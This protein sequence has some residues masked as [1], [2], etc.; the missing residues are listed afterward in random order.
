MNEPLASAAGNAVEVLNAVEFL[1]GAHRDTRLEEVTLALAAELLVLGGIAECRRL[2]ACA[3][4]RGAC[5]TGSA[6]EVFQKMVS[7]LGGPADFVA[8]PRKHLPQAKLVKAVAS[9]RRPG[10]VAA[11]DARALGLAVVAL[12]GGRTRAEDAIDHAVGLT[13]LA[14]I[15]DEVGPDRPLALVHARDED[16]ADAAVS[17]RPRR[18]SARRAARGPP[19]H[20]RAHRRGEALTWRARCFSSWIPS[21]SAAPRTRRNSA[22]RAP[23]RSAI[24]P[25]P[26]HPARPT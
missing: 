6:A 10:V 2:G 11:I 16:S 1:T 21:G 3:G 26:A 25:P 18:L 15:G 22:T 5:R 7:A 8:N 23:T 4:R 19:P 20:L 9:R 24:S 12:G 14:G 17:S 13:A